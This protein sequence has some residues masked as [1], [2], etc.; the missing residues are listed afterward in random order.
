MRDPDVIKQYRHIPIPAGA[1]LFWDQRLPH[2]NSM[3]NESS[4]TRRCIYGG[5]L[6]F[7]EKNIKY[8]EEQVRRL[9]NGTPQPDFWMKDHERLFKE[10]GIEDAFLNENGKELIGRK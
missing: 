1:A 9:E 8:N 4:T 3:K 2:A 10:N 5:F 7:T 6:P